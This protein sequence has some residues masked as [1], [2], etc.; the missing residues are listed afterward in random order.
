MSA[1]SRSVHDATVAFRDAAN[2][3][4]A[5]GRVASALSEVLKNVADLEA[6]VEE[7]E[8]TSI[9]PSAEE[10]QAGSGSAPIAANRELYSRRAQRSLPNA[11]EKRLRPRPRR[12]LRLTPRVLIWWGS[13][14][15]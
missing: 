9:P 3:A 2:A 7:L 1:S 10:A 11:R 12:W 5:L 4:I 6:C 13:W 15:S 14:K 8:R